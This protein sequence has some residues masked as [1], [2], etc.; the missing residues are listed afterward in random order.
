VI[1]M[2]D[3]SCPVCGGGLDNPRPMAVCATCHESLNST[4][5]PHSTGEFT[6]PMAAVLASIGEA[7]TI[8]PTGPT[9][10]GALKCSWCG[11]SA[12]QVKK[13]LTGGSAHICNEC[14]SLCSEILAAEL[15]EDWK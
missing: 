9:A 8:T 3:A 14:V 15:G 7:P 6:V 11:R 10:A 12:H 2:S 1:A 13:L 4:L 5:R